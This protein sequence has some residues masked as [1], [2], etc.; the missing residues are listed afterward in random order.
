MRFFL[1]TG[2]AGVLFAAA[3]AVALAGLRAGQNTLKAYAENSAPELLMYTQLYAT[4]L[5][6]GQAIRNIVLD[7]ANPK[8]YAN[9]DA[10]LKEFDSIMQ[11]G[12]RLTADNPTRQ[13][14][15]QEIR[16]QWDQLARLQEPIKAKTLDQAAA[17]TLLNKQATP[18]WRAIKDQLLGL[19]KQQE[20]IMVQ[21]KT[22]SKRQQDRALWLAV[23][24][25]VLAGGLGTALLILA[26]RNLQRRLRDLDVAMADLA[27]GKGDLTRRLPL[28]GQDEIG[29]IADKANQIT[30]FYQRFFQRLGLHSNGVASGSTELSATAESLSATAV[31]LDSHTQST[32][33]NAQTMAD[34][35][36]T[37]STS[38]ADVMALAQQSHTH[39]AASEQ[40][41]Q[42]GITT[43]TDTARAM[44]DISKA[45]A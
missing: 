11:T 3:L 18:A 12:V 44:E 39:S 45:T 4:G 27:S 25:G 15:L 10:A 29:R 32:Q 40:A 7:P 9:Y 20:A 42:H 41:I 26:I 36:Q 30:E 33:G 5:Q 19:V 43:G 22:E 34:A 31:Q 21:I 13:Q 23:G 14:T 37:L 38:L 24:V 28:E 2:M 8:A 35:M 1:A 16:L 6:T 17:I